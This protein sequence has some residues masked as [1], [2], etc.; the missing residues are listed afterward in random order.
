M[1]RNATIASTAGLRYAW[2]RGKLRTQ[3]PSVAM[4]PSTVTGST[5]A[6]IAAEAT[7]A[8]PIVCGRVECDA[9]ESS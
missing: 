6:L 4:T 5:S 7:I 3:P 1:Y 2:S 8:R 9:Y